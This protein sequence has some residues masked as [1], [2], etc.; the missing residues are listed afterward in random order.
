M[1]FV[2]HTVAID[3]IVKIKTKEKMMTKKRKLIPFRFFPAS[4]G[5]KGEA[6]ERAKIEYELDGLDRKIALAKVGCK[7]EPEEALAEAKI[8]LEEG[9]IDQGQHDKMVAQVLKKPWVEVK[10]MEV[11][12]DDPKAGY[13]ELDWNDEF[14][15][16]LQEK[17][18]VGDSDESVVNKWFN[19][20]CRTVLL[21]ELEDQDYGLEEQYDG[22]D[23][24]KVSEPDVSKEEPGDE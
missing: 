16:M 22:T 23:V 15:A 2:M 8:L 19:D 18:Y 9:E 13:M 1:S 7:N 10:K 20:I 14:V 17:G 21:Q 4:W 11:N 6:F 24:I 12:P 5:L 3:G